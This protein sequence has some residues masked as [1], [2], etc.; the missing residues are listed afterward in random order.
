M[1]VLDGA[2]L[3]AYIYKGVSTL[4]AAS[5]SVLLRILRRALAHHF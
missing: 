5:R 2:L 1:G 4:E 3:L